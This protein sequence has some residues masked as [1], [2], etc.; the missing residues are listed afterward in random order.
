M[1]KLTGRIQ[2]SGGKHLK[3]SLQNK[4]TSDDCAAFFL[5]SS[6]SR[7][8]QEMARLGVKAD[9]VADAGCNRI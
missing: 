1:R 3:L 7:K 2:M 4:G 5:G 6:S 8:E 9:C